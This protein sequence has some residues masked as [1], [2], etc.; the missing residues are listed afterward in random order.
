M[1]YIELQRLPQNFNLAF[2]HKKSKSKNMLK[3]EFFKKNS[4]VCLYIMNLKP[5]RNPHTNNQHPCVNN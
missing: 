3:F 4:P 2:G 1:I 5:Q